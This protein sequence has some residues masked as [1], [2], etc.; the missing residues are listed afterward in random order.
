[1]RHPDR[2][3]SPG[4]ES[5]RE[6]LS[7]VRA[8]LSWLAARHPGETVVVACHGGIIDGSLVEFLGVPDLG[9]GMDLRT[10]HA[11]LTSWEHHGRRWRL[12]GYNDASHLARMA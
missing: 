3:L 4:G 9:T 11:S 6:F 8:S 5:W 12:S 7:R 1:S 10:S 2:P